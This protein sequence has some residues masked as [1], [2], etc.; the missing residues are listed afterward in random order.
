MSQYGALAMANAGM[1]AASIVTHYYQG[2]TVQPVQDDM[3][4]R[5]NLEYDKKHVRVRGEAVEGDGTVQANL[6]G[7]IVTAGPGESFYFTGE[8]GAS[9]GGQDRRRCSPGTWNLPQRDA[10]LVRSGERGRQ[11]WQLRFRRPS[12]PLR[13]HRGTAQGFSPRQRD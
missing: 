10:H 7:N 5:V 2:T 4:I 13:N 11:G 3:N 12:L 6:G 1:D 8:S 9:S